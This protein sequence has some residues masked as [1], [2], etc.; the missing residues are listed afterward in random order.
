MKFCVVFMFCVWS[1]SS[2]IKYIPY[3]LIAGFTMGII[4]VGQLN[5]ALG[6]GLKI[7]PHI[8]QQL[9]TVAKGITLVNWHAMGVTALT[10]L[11]LYALP[12]LTKAI[13]PGIIAVIVTTIMVAD[14]DWPV[15]TIASKF[16]SIPAGFPDLRFPPFSLEA[17]R[18]LMLPAFTIAALGG[19]ESLLSASVADGMTDTRHNSNQ[20]LIGQGIANVIC[21][22]FG[23][24]SA[25]GAIA[26]TAANIRSGARFSHLR[27]NQRT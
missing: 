2:L 1:L 3:P 21:P 27:D 8:P 19:I 24:I 22:I 10:L 18:G 26:R 15:A 16:G 20:E 25:T 14:L 9:S 11:I 23:G 12:R 4:F 5:E 13:P 7:Q 6:L 17:V